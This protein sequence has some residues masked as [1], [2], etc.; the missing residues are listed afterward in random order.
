MHSRKILVTVVIAVIMV[1]YFIAYF[2]FLMTLMSGVLR[3]VFGIIPFVFSAIMVKV[4][5]ERID[6]IKK[7]EEDD[8]SQY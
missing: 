8:L 4:C 7:G 1:I 3:Y 5:A 6:E 2:G